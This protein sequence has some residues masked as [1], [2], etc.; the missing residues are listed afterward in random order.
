VIAVILK[1]INYWLSNTGFIIVPIT[2]GKMLEEHANV[3]EAH[4]PSRGGNTV[5]WMREVA[6]H[7]PYYGD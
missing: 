4:H 2:S 6:K 7:M 3:A 5:K 1:K